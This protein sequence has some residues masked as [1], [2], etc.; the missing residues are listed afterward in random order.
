M[1]YLLGEDERVEMGDYVAIAIAENDATATLVRD[2]LMAHRI[3]AVFPPS[4]FPIYPLE[5]ARVR[6]WVPKRLVHQAEPLLQE[7][8]H[9]WA[10]D[11]EDEEN[12]AE[13]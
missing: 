10:F 12:L 13:D 9:E 6:I 5:S 3:P 2:F 7:L 8:E 4:S 1:W 11:H